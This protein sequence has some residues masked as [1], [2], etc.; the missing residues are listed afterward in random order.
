MNWSYCFHFGNLMI[1]Y[2]TKFWMTIVCTIANSVFP[3][4]VLA[5]RKINME[6]KHHPFVKEN[7]LPNHMFIFRGV[8]HP[9]PSPNLQVNLQKMP[10]RTMPWYWCGP[11]PKGWPWFQLHGVFPKTT[12]WLQNVDFC[13]QI[14]FSFMFQG[15]QYRLKTTSH[16]CD[17][18]DFVAVS[19]N[20]WI[21]D[22]DS[23]I[24]ETSI[25]TGLLRCILE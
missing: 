20:I 3:Q 12:G 19:R 22:F 11:Y 13:V 21:L 5:L 6:P 15:S 8:D 7:H 10:H 1:C 23:L 9:H 16:S 14:V 2:V 24:L 4:K 17:L 25:Y 18:V